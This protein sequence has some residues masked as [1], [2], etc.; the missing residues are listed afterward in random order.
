MA[1]AGT[2]AG[3]EARRHRALADAHTRAAVEEAAAA[4]RYEVA[5]VTESRVAR[6]LSILAAAGYHLLPDRGWPGSRSANVDL[7][8]AGPTGV[9]IVDTKAWK[10]VTIQHGRIYRGQADVSEDLANLA[11]LARNTDGLLADIGLAPG[12]VHAVAVL[13][14]HRNIRKQV[15]P[16]E[17]V[18]EY[19]VARFIA[20]RGE[21]LSLGQIDLVVKS[22][23]DQFPAIRPIEAIDT[24]L[25]EPLMLEPFI[26]EPDPTSHGEQKQAPGKHNPKLQTQ[27][28]EEPEPFFTREDLAAVQ[29]E[30]VLADPIESWMSFLDP[31]QA[32]LARRSFN[33]PARIRGSAGTGKTV[34]GLHR[35][36]YLARANGATK[37]GNKVLF[38]TYTKSLP[39]VF[40][41][42][43][44]RMAPELTDA[45]E[46]TGIH[47]FATRILRDRGIPFRLDAD[48][49]DQ[50]FNQAWG[51]QPHD[52]PL[53]DSEKAGGNGN[54]KDGLTSRYWHEE[55]TYVIKGRGITRFDQYA[56]LTR[57]GRRHR[58][59]LDQRR[60]VWSLHETYE[61]C[62]RARKANDFADVILL[63]LASVRAT[64]MTTYSAVIVDEAQDL[65]CT[66]V[67]LL[68]S[69]VG[70]RP[71][72]FTLIG[73]GQQ[74][75][76]PGG[77]ALAELGISLA[78]RGVVL[79]VNHRNTREILEFAAT[80]V[81]RDEFAD[82]EGPAS[83]RDA[84]ADITR[85]GP[86]P[87][88]ASF[89]SRAD[90][91]AAVVTRVQDALARVGTTT[92]DI[93]VLTLNRADA[94]SLRH[95]L[96]AA[97]IPA[98]DL[99]DYSGRPTNA[100]KVGTIK[101]SK[102]LEFKEV[103]VARVPRTALEGQSEAA[104]EADQERAGMKRRELFVA[105]TRARDRAWVGAL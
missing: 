4:A 62:L 90:H 88:V 79:N 18:G 58:L 39:G 42:L 101:R 14:G 34:V 99:A 41:S 28:Q 21:R 72:G 84:V 73:D 94:A 56:D 59:T 43:L 68:H 85:S 78:G 82:I 23:L 92:G 26:L 54:G 12:E 104:A 87:T 100:V 60:A 51:K 55:I 52:S 53:R 97:S 38:A 49:A 81:A 70:N 31:A 36:A 35:A 37:T 19:D 102:G 96:S 103:L 5:E 22:L 16:V 13:A 27:N 83:T 46:F 69:L 93:A 40:A 3:T 91:D 6:E 20:K 10:D 71:D 33:G 2:S 7:I 66:M 44:E 11:D 67:A 50:A 76:Y 61:Q 9:F 17:I 74:T 98:I 77:Y 63:A 15:G 32:K 89:D 8:V 64:P 30:A 24:T 65:T 29:L 86:A 1:A 105:L 57:I 45:V 95:V 47:A 48:A 75:I 80:F 25:L